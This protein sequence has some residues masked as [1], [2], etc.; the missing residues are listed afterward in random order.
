MMCLGEIVKFFFTTGVGSVWSV[1]YL[2]GLDSALEELTMYNP[3]K[4]KCTV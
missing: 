4:L 1:E 3:Q 2:C